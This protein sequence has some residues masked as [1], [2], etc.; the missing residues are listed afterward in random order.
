M[1]S[2]PYSEESAA[3][4]KALGS[5]NHAE[6]VRH[7]D[8]NR[9]GTGTTSMNT[10]ADVYGI[11]PPSGIIYVI[12]AIRISFSDATALVASGFGGLA[13]LANGCLLEIREDPGGSPEQSVRDLTL[14]APIKTH[15]QLAAMG[16]TEIYSGAAD[17]LVQS[18]VAAGA[19]FRLD[20][21]RGESLVFAVQ[22]DLSGLTEMGV[23]AVGRE[24]S[25]APF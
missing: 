5:P 24:Y 4:H 9:I 6:L 19:P 10:T 22:D 7:L 3:R 13:A 15:V 11:K 21:N 18:A 16:P 1:P 20:G 23:V 17:C 12:D 14:G 2:L 25:N 8:T